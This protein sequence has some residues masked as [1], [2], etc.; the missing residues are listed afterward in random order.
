MTTPVKPSGKSQ[1]KSKKVTTSLSKLEDSSL[2]QRV[3]RHVNHGLGRDK[4][5]KQ[6]LFQALA[7][8]VKEKMLQR[9]R[10]T[11]QADSQFER[12]Q[13]AY[14]SLEFLMGRAMGNAVMNL[15]LLQETQ[16]LL[17]AYAVELEELEQVEHDAG[18]G[19]GGLGRLAACFLDSCASLDLSVTGYGIRYEYG[20]FAQKLVD[21]FQVERPDRW[22]RE[23]NPW[24]VRVSEHNVIVPFFGHTSSYVD[25]NGRRNVVW[26]DTQDVLAVAYDMPVPG[27]K[28]DRVNTL[29]LWKSE[30]TDDFDLEEFNQG[31]YTEAVARKNMAEQITMVLYP[32]DAS[33]N[34]KELRLRQQYF[35]SSASL[36]DLLNNWV[37]QHGTD[38]S[39]FAKFNVMQ[40]NDT[41]P[42]IAIPELMRLLIDEYF[43]EW[44][45]AWQVVS[46]TMAYTNHTLLPEALE[47][48]SVRM[49]EHMLPR[50]LEIIF[51]INARYLDLVAHQWPGDEQKLAAMSIIE[52]GNEPHVRMAYLA[53]VASFS[54][55]GVAGLHSK[56][57]TS[58]LFKDFYQLWPHKFNNKTNGVTPRRWL[59]NCNPQL[60][61]L[62]TKRLGNDWVTDLSHLNALNAFTD[63]KG[64]IKEWQQVKQNNKAVLQQLIKAECDVDFDTNMLFDVQVKRIHEYKRQLLNILHVIH[65][66][67]QIQQGNTSNMVPRCVLI[68]GKAAPGYAMAKLIIKLASNV[69]HM[70]NSDPSVT[71]FL[72]VA[73]LP[74]YNVSAME[75]ICPATDLSE[76]ISTAGKEASGTGN[77]KF[78]MNG[79]V[80]I[81]T[82]DGA[83][84]EMLEEVGE[85]NFFLFGLTA[86]QVMQ[87]RQDYR[88]QHFIDA[89]PALNEVLTLIDSGHFSLLEPGIFSPLITAI[90]SCDD[91]W[92]T[93]ADFESYRL[94][95]EHVAKVYKNQ[96]AWT[97][98]SIRNTAA[99]GRFSSDV[100]IAKYRDEIWKA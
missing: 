24:E 83:N 12:K 23:G 42:S 63:D 47:R 22:L 65:L 54:V 32:N 48:W 3:Q 41:H 50:I 82:L 30:A 46:Q 10:T 92:M 88:P 56:L 9:W 16:E 35:L 20:M 100:T 76:Q 2:A 58:G 33:E 44:D 78:M 95:Q 40:L 79:A 34:G 6:E 28:N 11:R 89:S 66:Y 97:Q 72:R 61:S 84:V 96:T 21:G 26:L 45:Q 55:N 38:F 25:P 71:P 90:T 59:A 86:E 80:T 91:P 99:S 93:A 81:G 62:L 98:M 68:G 70:V 15:D 49:L 60:A 31:D 87:Q 37:R 13:V 29:R 1:S 19:N 75:K 36:Q 39:D 64:F 27:Y 5:D 7:L 17:K 73:F 43:L 85:D 74:N 18:L 8:S 94:S 53:I 52:E 69:A 77:M 57:L 51:E 4:Y 14:L 67:H